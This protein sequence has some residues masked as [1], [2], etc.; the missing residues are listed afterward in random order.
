MKQRDAHKEDRGE[1][2]KR[3]EQDEHTRRLLVNRLFRRTTYDSVKV[4][5]VVSSED[6]QCLCRGDSGQHVPV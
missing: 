4:D 5:S 3:A 1:E 6:R 2:R